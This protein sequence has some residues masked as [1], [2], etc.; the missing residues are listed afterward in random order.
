MLLEDL[1]VD[2]EVLEAGTGWVVKD[3]GAC[4]AEHCVP[5][6][7]EA[8]SADGRTDATILAQRLGMPLVVDLEHG[9]WALGPE[10]TVTGHALS[11]AVAPELELPDRHGSTFRLSSLRGQKVVLIAWASW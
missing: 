1:L 4:K 2:P 9:I 11:S 6:P 10:T 3:K 5:L 7:P 8:R